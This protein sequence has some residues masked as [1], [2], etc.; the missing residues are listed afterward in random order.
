DTYPSPSLFTPYDTQFGRTAAMIGEFVV[1][2]NVREIAKAYQGKAWSYNFAVP[3]AIHGMDLLFTWWR[4]DL[5]LG[6]FQLDFDFGLITKNNLAT[7]WQR[8]LVSFAINGDP[9]S[10]R[11]VIA[12]PLPKT[13]TK[14]VT[15]TYT[16]G[17]ELGVLRLDNTWNKD[18]PKDNCDFFAGSK[19]WRQFAQ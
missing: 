8:Y 7:T 10:D 13:W 16:Y 6:N 2:C 5:N 9:N 1:S 11:A 17:L 12:F 19:V 4:T 3:P 18:T 15:S 14:A